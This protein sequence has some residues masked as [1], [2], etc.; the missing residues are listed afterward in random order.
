[1]SFDANF[2]LNATAVFSAPGVYVLRLTVSDGELSSSDDVVVTAEQSPFNQAPIVDAGIDRPVP[3]G[4]VNFLGGTARDDGLPNPPAALT[5][6]WVQIS[7]PAPVAIDSPSSL[8]TPATGFDVSGN[9]LFRLSVTDGDLTTSDDV[10]YVANQAAIF[11][12]GPDQT[13][14]F[15]RVAE[16]VGSVTDDGF[17][18]P[19]VI[20]SFWMLLDGPAPVVFSDPFS[21]R[22]TVRFRAP[23]RYLMALGGGDG[24][25]VSG[26]DGIEVTVLHPACQTPTGSTP[27]ASC[28][29]EE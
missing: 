22:T 11:D 12:A 26:A 7:G 10:T 15:P 20:Q 28:L 4:I 29:P 18:E 27:A 5:V 24:A 2:L 8:I 3:A 17:P 6:S 21:L 19:S 16:L 23:G 9:Y 1:V 14:V 13:I 25:S